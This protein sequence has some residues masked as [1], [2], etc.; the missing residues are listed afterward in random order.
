MKK[1]IAFLTSFL[2]L[3]SLSGYAASLTFATEATYPPFESLSPSGEM[4]GFDIDIVHALCEK[5]QAQCTINNQA[6]DSLIPS[7]Q[8]K[9]FDAIFGAINI[10]P[11]RAKQVNFTDPYYVNSVSIIASKNK[12]PELA[13]SLA[14]KTIGVQT[15]TTL[16]QYLQEKYGD[17]VKINTYASE[18]ST[19]LDLTSG[20]ID[21]VMGDTPLI[22]QWLKQNGKNN[23]VIVGTPIT[24][25][26][27]FGAGYGIAV[28][29]DNS[30]L[31]KQLNDAIA[32]I[33][34]D[35][36]Y[37]KIVKKYFGNP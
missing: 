26:K 7:L 25:K 24:D 21:A 1:F 36:T 32:A 31:L 4:Q 18:Q 14:G 17:E 20:R 34:A 3:F 5:M 8:L 22:V 15:G 12:A 11:E 28:H 35:G 13:K 30:I 37:E 23:Y 16:A 19:F 10:T 9:K 2:L 33:K 29:K 27:Y 6:F